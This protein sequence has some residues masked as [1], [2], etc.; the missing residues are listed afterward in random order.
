M[1]ISGKRHII[2]CIELYPKLNSFNV[3]RNKKKCLIFSVEKRVVTWL[4]L[5]LRNICVHLYI[6]RESYTCGHFI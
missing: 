3:N 1:S 6:Y 5:A 2:Y 4:G